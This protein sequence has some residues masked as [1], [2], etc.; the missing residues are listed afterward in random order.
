MLAPEELETVKASF[1][2]QKHRTNKGEEA[3]A[4]TRKEGSTHFFVL[5]GKIEVLG[6]QP[7]TAREH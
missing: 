4:V 7:R 1:T 3:T 2:D 5:A 6:L